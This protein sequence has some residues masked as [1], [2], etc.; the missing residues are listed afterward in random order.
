MKFAYDRQKDY[1]DIDVVEKR[2]ASLRIQYV[3]ESLDFQG[4]YENGR[5]K[6]VINNAINFKNVNKYP[7]NIMKFCNGMDFEVSH[8]YKL[9]NETVEKYKNSRPKREKNNIQSEME[10]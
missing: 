1:M 4:L 8:E 7:E 9:T 10:R 2:L 6:I 3:E 5:N